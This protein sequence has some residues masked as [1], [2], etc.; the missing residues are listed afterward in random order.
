MNLRSSY[1]AR[2][3]PLAGSLTL[4]FLIAGC[5]GGGGSG[6]RTVSTPPPPLASAPAPSPTPAPPSASAPAPAPAPTPSPSPAPVVSGG[7]TPQVLPVSAAFD[8]AEFRR[9]DGPQQH[10]AAQ[11]WQA[12]AT[13]KGV[14]IAIVDSGIDT[15]NPEFTGR[16][17][18]ASRDMFAE[19]GALSGSY[20]HGT[21]VAQVAAGARDN[22]GILGMAHGASVLALRAD[23]PGSCDGP[24]GGSGCAF[25]D[26]TIA[27]AVTYAADNGARIVNLSLGGGSVS[28][29]LADAVR[30]ATGRGTLVVVSAGNDGFDAPTDFTTRLAAAGGGAVLV[31]GS[32][33]EKGQISAFSNRAGS[34]VAGY[35]AARGEAVC[36]TY[37]AGQ[38]FT[39]P[40]GYARAFS[41]TSFAAPQVSGAAALLA[42]AFPHLTGKELA[43]ILLESAFDAGAA[44]PDA[45]Y[46]SGILD[47]ARAFRPLGATALAGTAASVTPDTATGTAS[48]PMGDALLSVSLPTL[49]TDR[50]ARA[51]STDL[52]VGLA[53][54]PVA[55]ALAGALAPGLRRAGGAAGPAS[56][57]FALA[58]ADRPATALDA[59][60]DRAGNAQA[61]PAGLVAAQAA[62]AVTAETSLAI[63]YRQDAGSLA[64]SLRG[65]DVGQ[66]LIA[67]A[68]S[69]AAAAWQEPGAAFAM[70]H[71]LAGWGVTLAAQQG[72]ARE[73]AW[74]LAPAAHL[75][76]EDETMR[77]FALAFDRALGP[78]DTVFAMSWMAEDATL[79]GARLHD[80]FG[81]AG[82]DTLFVDLAADWRLAPAWRIG[83]ALRHGITRARAGGVIGA[84]TR[85]A[86]SAFA[87]DIAR[88]DLLHPGDRLAL[89]ISQP[90]R[91]ES[92][93]LALSLPSR[94]DYATLSAEHTVHRLSLAPRGREIDAELAWSGRLLAGDAAA[95]VFYRHQPGHHVAMP[96]EAGLALRWSRGF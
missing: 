43:A 34:N 3:L 48:G 94:W 37:Q 95:S 70:R 74:R 87:F 68:P 27:Q 53:P 69:A 72:R 62:L 55:M 65:R 32:V 21:R 77:E 61:R 23:Q 96:A 30:A 67:G 10:N 41:G 9:S 56:L 2:R 52:G 36:C 49:V 88:D 8:T 35:I 71:E 44:G 75:T 42:Q 81:L 50:Y 83:A 54:A 60:G 38:I 29:V 47:L 46:G 89:R 20:D 85:L 5:G 15:A 59:A 86:S 91:V 1:A 64:A 4:A 26:S 19:R 39:D 93:A 40:N 17:A 76:D 58:P 79:L 90:L 33:D 45:V 51:F 18:A 82:A 24:S 22:A 80:A 28:S 11:A 16:I 92:G 66:F 57:G 84:D 6:G 12:G 31:V 14:T 25:F 73:E 78:L 7:S 13:G 63:G